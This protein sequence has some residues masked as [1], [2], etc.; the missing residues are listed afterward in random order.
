MKKKKNGFIFG[1]VLIITLLI[2]S[3]TM[4][5][6]MLNAAHAKGIINDRNRNESYYIA[7]MGLELA[8]AALNEKTTQLGSGGAGLS[9]MEVSR[10]DYSYSGGG[11][12]AAFVFKNDTEKANGKKNIFS[13]SNTD[14]GGYLG[15]TLSGAVAT[16]TSTD[17]IGYIKISGDLLCTAENEVYYR[18]VC[19][20]KVNAEDSTNFPSDTHTLTMFVFKDDPNNPKIYNGNKEVLN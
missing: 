13:L 19:T 10:V 16:P 20:G 11:R 15:I 3:V 2:T 4:T 14:S 18:I 7:N 17:I 12:E 8:Y 9:I 5:V 1:T 6:T